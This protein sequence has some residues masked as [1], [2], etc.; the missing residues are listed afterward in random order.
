MWNDYALPAPDA[1][2]Q[3][4][5][6]AY[7]TFTETCEATDALRDALLA[8]RRVVVL[9][10]AGISTESGIPDFRSPGGLWSQ[11]DPID[12]NA[13]CRSEE[14]RL[15]DWRRRFEMDALFRRSKPNAA[16]RAIAQAA[17]HGPVTTVVTQ[18]IDG[19]HATAGTPSEKLIEIHGTGTHAH[20][21]KCGT[22]SEIVDAKAQ[23]EATGRSPR[24]SLCDGLVKAAIV[25]FGEAMPEA[26]TVDA[27]AAAEAC[28]LFIAA[29]TSLVVYPAA[30]LPLVALEAGAKLV[31]ASR[32]PTEQ[33]RFAAIVIRTALAETFGPLERIKFV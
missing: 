25:S 29:G 14:A 3:I 8:A 15:E 19:L 30:G 31:I 4:G 2:G 21:L 10:G 17:T 22:R 6:M 24:C 7:G 9:T 16:H 13:F 12:Y 20:C 11:M 33:D 28:D 27:F 1:R 23:I 18:N 32:E 26:K 5:G